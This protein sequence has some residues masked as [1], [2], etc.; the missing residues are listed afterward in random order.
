M[1]RQKKD[2]SQLAKATD[3]IKFWEMKDDSF[4]TV[5]TRSSFLKKK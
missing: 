5:V 4:D 2:E 3:T 1:K